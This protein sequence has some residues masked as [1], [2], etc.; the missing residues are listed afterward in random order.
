MLRKLT[1]VRPQSPGRARHRPCDRAVLRDQHPVRRAV[2]IGAARSDR[3]PAVHAVRGHQAGALDASR[4][5][6]ICGSTTPSSW[7]SWARI[8]ARHARRVEELL[9]EYRRLSG[10][11]VQLERLDPQPFSP[12]EDLAVAEGL[13]GLPL[14]DDGTQAYFGLVRAQQHRR[15]PGGQLSGAGAREL[16]RVRP[17]APGPRSRQSRQ[18]RRRGPGRSAADGLPVQSVPAV[19]RA[20]RDVSVLRRAL[21]RRQAGADRG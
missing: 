4:N 5:R 7:T 6:S 13:E 9:A 15:H 19:A 17:D 18:A 1:A 2:Q 11:R 8:S 14:N 21:P 12:E 3:G 10:G 16:P 20:R